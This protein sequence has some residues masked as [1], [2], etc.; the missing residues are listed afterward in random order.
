M[1]S[2]ASAASAVDLGVTI[3]LTDGATR[4]DGI[5]VVAPV[6]PVDWSGAAVEAARRR[7]RLEAQ[8][9][10]AG[11][12]L[13]IVV[14]ASVLAVWG[15]TAV[16]VVLMQATAL[17]TSGDYRRPRITLSATTDIPRI[18]GRLGLTA[19]LVALDAAFQPVN[20]WVF[21][22]VVVSSA[23]VVATRFATFA[24]LRLMRVR[25][26]LRQ[27]AVI[28]GAGIVGTQMAEY[29]DRH[30]VF[31]IELVGLVDE[32]E[33]EDGR[34]LLGSV[35]DLSRILVER[36]ARYVILAYGSANDDRTVDAVRALPPGRVEVFVVPRFFDLGA[37]AGDPLLDDAWG[38][39]LVW[40]RRRALRARNL[41]AKRI[42]DFTVSAFLLLLTLPVLA[43]AAVAVAVTSRGP[44]LFRQRRIGQHGRPFDLLKLRSMRINDDSDTTWNVAVDARVTRVGRF[45]RRTSL[46]ELP[47][48]LNVLKGDMSLV[49][50]RPERP[51]YV[52][53]FQRTIPR[54]EDR[55]R[56]PVGLTGWAQIHGLR[57]DSSIDDRVRFDNNYI[58]H[59]SIWR[60]LSI[61]F[62]TASAMMRGE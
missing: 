59:W 36:S 49:G 24:L 9:L 62:R 1:R 42:F 53:Q 15:V 29:F 22:F 17:V 8:I 61:L 27:R 51:F 4:H 21:T 6:E 19:A 16:I 12:L 11:D 28:V 39:P 60:D 20:Q 54:Y 45:L 55:H 38:V 7:E 25:G 41:R 23:A 58:E 37:A 50:P 43:A 13:A 46:D 52:L 18:V 32:S 33:G 30:K 2:R 31:G 14:T 3:D 56:S 34:R 35:D 10:A 57:G 40:L 26:W 5:E 48:L 47:Q 44:I